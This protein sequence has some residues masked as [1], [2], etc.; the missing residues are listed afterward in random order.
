MQD[1]GETLGRP[2][3]FIVGCGHSGTS[4][5]ANMFAAH[6]DVYIP[7]RETAAFTTDDPSLWEA[8]VTEFIASDRAVLAEKTPGH[9][10]H[11]DLIRGRTPDPR[12]VASV[13]D[14]RDVAA[15]YIT[16]F[17]SPAPGIER[18]LTENAIVAAE[19]DRP[20][21]LVV[22]Y[23]ALIDN[24]EGVLAQVCEFCEITFSPAMLSYHTQE[25]LWFNET[26]VTKGSG[27]MGPQH[28]ALR[29]WQI[30]Q[31]IFDGRGK[32]RG[33]LDA[34]TLDMLKTDEARG[35]MKRFDYEWED[36]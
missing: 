20:D 10:R 24:A 1:V 32:W 26:S 8:V 3:L 21:V 5:L 13:R 18:W 15:S 33:V 27:K 17:G 6:P 7:L 9:V 4:L 23:E 28:R 29:N 31:P 34:T 16:R 11:M 12:F 2:T 35:L 25:R 30:N 19:Q 22:K 36:L 14:P